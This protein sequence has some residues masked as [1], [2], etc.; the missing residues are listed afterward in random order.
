MRSKFLPG[1]LLLISSLLPTA[2]WAG[3]GCAGCPQAAVCAAAKPKPEA[4]AGASACATST[5]STEVTGFRKHEPSS[6]L[7]WTKV[8]MTSADI[9]KIQVEAQEQVELRKDL[10]KEFPTE[11][12]AKTMRFMTMKSQL[13][14][15][16]GAEAA[17]KVEEFLRLRNQPEATPAP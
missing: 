17:T 15:R 16:T 11:V 6:G 1:F 3:P 2:L 7:E 8:S 13:W 9:V 10:E 12:A 5:L 14:V 4:K